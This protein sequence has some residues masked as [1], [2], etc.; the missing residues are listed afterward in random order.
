M[1]QKSPL[2]AINCRFVTELLP[3]FLTSGLFVLYINKLHW[4]VS[5][6][7]KH[8]AEMDEETIFSRRIVYDE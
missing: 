2:K 3:A 7:A 1:Y 8:L 5:V 4:I 6:I